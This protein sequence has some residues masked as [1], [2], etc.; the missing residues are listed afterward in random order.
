VWFSWGIYSAIDYSTLWSVRLL[1]IGCYAAE[2]LSCK[3]T[4]ISTRCFFEEYDYKVIDFL[5]LDPHKPRFCLLGV[6]GLLSVL[7]PVF[8]GEYSSWL[9][10]KRR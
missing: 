2:A 4:F 10:F 7:M 5:L 9:C 3:F 1:R 6:C 8:L